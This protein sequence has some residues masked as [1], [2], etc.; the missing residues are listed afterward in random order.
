[1][2][3]EGLS[4]DCVAFFKTG[5][6]QKKCKEWVEENNAAVKTSEVKWKE[7]VQKLALKT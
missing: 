2:I 4:E 3:N 5:K 6:E 1:M 7:C